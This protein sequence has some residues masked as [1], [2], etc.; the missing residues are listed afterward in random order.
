MVIITC[1]YTTNA[2]RKSKNPSNDERLLNMMMMSTASCVENCFLRAGLEKRGLCV[3]CAQIGLT[4][5]VRPVMTK[6]TCA[7]IVPLIRTASFQYRTP[8]TTEATWW[9]ETWQAYPM[10]YRFTYFLKCPRTCYFVTN[11]TYSR[12]CCY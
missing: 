11:H 10:S 12:I 6:H 5:C 1:L 4:F 8:G 2:Y 3:T 7:T 9:Y